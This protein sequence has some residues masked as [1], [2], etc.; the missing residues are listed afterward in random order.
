MLLH[1]FNPSHDE[2]LAAN[3]PYYTPTLAARG[4]ER[5]LAALP[6]H[7]AEPE[8]AVLLATETPQPT[9]PK[10]IRFV[11][12]EAMDATLWREIDAIRPWGWDALLV[13]RLRGMGAPGHLLPD[14]ETLKRIRRLSSRQTAVRLLPLLRAELPDSI[15]LSR[16]CTSEKEVRQSIR[17]YGCVVLKSPWSCSGRGVFRAAREDLENANGT[18]LL[19]R[20]RRILMQQGAIEAEPFYDRQMDFAME[21]EAE[22]GGRLR[23][24]GLALFLTDPSGR[25]GGNLV[26]GQGTLEALLP[27][28]I[29]HQLPALREIIR[30]QLPPLIKGYAG[31]LGIDMMA[32]KHNGETWL[33]PCVEINLRHTMGRVALDLYDKD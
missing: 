33:H 24:L 21:F 10:H 12:P 4:L 30:R 15:G 29:R 7:W 27:E 18:S 22:P 23:H 5:D 8:D 32:V 1:V 13:H 26:A 11:R 19:Q 28:C 20:V 31:P 25:Y 9:E 6:A 3:S 17:E 16:F 14:A 2:A